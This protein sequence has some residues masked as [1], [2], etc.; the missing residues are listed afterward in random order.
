MLINFLIHILYIL[1]IR[2]YQNYNVGKDIEIALTEI[3]EL[4]NEIDGLMQEEMHKRNI[5]QELTDE[6]NHLQ[7]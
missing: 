5:I 3:R 4:Q 7:G 6:R 1:I 2:F